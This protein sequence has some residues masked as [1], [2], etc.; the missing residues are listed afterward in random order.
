MSLF[1]FYNNRKPRQF[2]HK[3]ILY[4]PEKDEFNERI[5]KIKKEM[6]VIKD[7]E[8]QPTIKGEFTKASK[9]VTRKQTRESESGK[10]LISRTF[11]LIL[12]LVL[13]LVVFY[14]LFLK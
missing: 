13:L 10:T 4:D 8:Y 3:P 5:L 14:F 6:G 11:T 12:I 1:F 2:Q 7:D 9:H